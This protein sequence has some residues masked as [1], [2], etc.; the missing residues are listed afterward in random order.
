MF[1]TITAKLQILPSSDGAAQL[2]ETMKA[3]SA[4]CNYVSR[5]V[6]TTHDM[7]QSSL[8]VALYYNLR[9]RFGLRS[10]MA[11]SVLKTV[12]ARYKTILSNQ[13]E[14][15]KPDFK[16]PEY[17]LVWNRDYSLKE[18][19]F[20][21]N[22]LT[23]RL[24]V[25]FFSKAMEKYFDDSYQFGT[26]KLVW[27]HKKW[28]LHIPVTHEVDDVADTEIKNVIGVDRGI[29]F[30][31]TTYDSKH[32]TTFVNGRSIKQKRAQYAAV[33]KQLQ[34]RQTPS[35][36]RRLK[37]IGS[38]ENRWMADV[39]HQISKALVENNPKGTL[40]VL[41]DLT[42]VRSATERIALRHRY[43][44]VSWSFYDLE[45]KLAYKAQ[46]YGSKVIEV[47]PSYTSQTCPMC[48]HIDR[49]SRDK[50]HHIFHCTNCGYESNDDRIA[51]MN[52]HAKGIAY[53]GEY[54]KDTVK[55]VVTE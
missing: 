10:Q 53:L 23:G 32:K 26:A 51:A 27:K 50:K 17:D 4:A 12:L 54:L 14:W 45:Q 24:E 43:V 6:F 15:I 41:E 1:Q 34:Q 2:S 13:K 52:L 20:S 5:Y 31:V 8:N 16:H 48:G 7:K 3:Y 37:T 11:Q 38:R 36:R 21:V 46:R 40:F 30:V 25:P 29:N 44:S 55:T 47:N 42:G 49:N 22:T 28:F 9:S 39:N 33:R 19:R 35:A 18:D